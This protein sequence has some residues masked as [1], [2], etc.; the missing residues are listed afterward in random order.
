MDRINRQARL[1]AITGPNGFNEVLA[2]EKYIERGTAVLLANQNALTMNPRR[3]INYPSWHE[4]YV[5]DP[6]KHGIKVPACWREDEAGFIF[7]DAELQIDGSGPQWSEYSFFTKKVNEMDN[8]NMVLPG[9]TGCVAEVHASPKTGTLVIKFQDA[10]A[11][12]D[13]D[14]NYERLYNSE[15]IY[16]AWGDACTVHLANNPGDF[17]F[18]KLRYVIIDNIINQGTLWT[19]QDVL[20]A[21][22]VSPVSIMAGNKERITF[23]RGDDNTCSEWFKMLIGT[24]NGR[25]VA[26]MCADHAQAL[27]KQVRKIYAWYHCPR[28]M[29]G[30]LVF[31]LE[32]VEPV[33]IPA[34][35]AQRK[36]TRRDK[37]K[38][39]GKSVVGSI[40]K[41]FRD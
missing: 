23:E 40:K 22:G 15:L 32:D 18:R 1:R 34:D 33:A 11:D 27:G 20:I 10:K 24:A 13:P 21:E 26:R 5:S 16:Q 6:L 28:E 38:A 7:S 31:E 8:L 29:V 9:Y 12:W 41:Q 35:L 4:R 17:C 3:E 14:T 25:P 36:Q 19:I 30:A 2:P 37:L 39:F